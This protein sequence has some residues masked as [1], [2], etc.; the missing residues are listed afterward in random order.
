[1][2]RPHLYG[3]SIISQRPATSSRILE[4]LQFRI[5]DTARSSELPRERTHNDVGP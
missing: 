3:R 5:W 4:D 1:M 2:S